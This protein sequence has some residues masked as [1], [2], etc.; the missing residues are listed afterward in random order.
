MVLVELDQPAGAFVLVGPQ[1]GLEQ[2][3]HAEFLYWIVEWVFPLSVQAQSL[4]QGELVFVEPQGVV[5]FSSKLEEGLVFFHPFKRDE[6]VG[7]VGEQ[8]KAVFVAYV[9]G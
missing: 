6:E 7:S 8:V 5:L 3:R 1:L 2:G 4:E 9:A